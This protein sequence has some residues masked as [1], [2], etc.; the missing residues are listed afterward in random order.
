[1]VEQLGQGP[2][3]VILPAGQGGFLLG[4]GRGFEALQQAKLI[5]NMPQLIGVQARACAPLWAL[6][7]YGPAGLSWTA[8]GPTLAE[9]V[10]VSRP[11]RGDAVL[12]LLAAH[13]GQLLAVD[14]EKILPARDELAHRGFYVE[15]TSALVWDALAQLAGRLP[16]PI[17]LLLT[18]SGLKSSL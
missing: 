11:L 12:A 10:R 16:E 3:S 8:E 6:F 17:V 5:S 4:I 15:P 9:G 7:T 13:Q 18:G 2:G 1:M 14:E